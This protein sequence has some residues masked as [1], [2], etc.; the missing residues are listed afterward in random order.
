[1]PPILC[2]CH[3][4]GKIDGGGGRGE[5]AEGKSLEVGAV[6]VVVE[7]GLRVAGA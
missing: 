6:V 3:L 4:Q 1:M 2:V 5:G 7:A